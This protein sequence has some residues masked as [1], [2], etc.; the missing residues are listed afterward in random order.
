[1]ERVRHGIPMGARHG[2]PLSVKS[3]A[4]RRGLATGIPLGASHGHT[5]GGLSGER[6]GG[7][8]LGRA[9]H[10]KQGASKHRLTCGSRRDLAG[11]L[12]KPD[13]GRTRVMQGPRVGCRTRTDH[14]VGIIE[15]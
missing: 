7:D 3:R 15:N 1:M 8:R 10:G 13:L 9:R 11:T 5:V 14:P 12:A 6:P 4:Y 2:Q